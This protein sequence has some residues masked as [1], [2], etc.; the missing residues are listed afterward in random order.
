MV[1]DRRRRPRRVLRPRRGRLDGADKADNV[2]DAGGAD[3]QSTSAQS[4]AGSVKVFA[5]VLPQHVKY[6]A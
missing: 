1:G 6:F 5:T 3:V 2:V 4:H